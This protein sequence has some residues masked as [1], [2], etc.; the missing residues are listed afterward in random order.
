MEY[1]S[2]RLIVIETV[3]MV[4]W[5]VFVLVVCTNKFSVVGREGQMSQTKINTSTC[6]FLSPTGSRDDR[7]NCGGGGG[8]MGL[9]I[10][11]AHS[12]FLACQCSPLKCE[13]TD[14]V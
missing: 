14:C 1:N 11:F 3:A 5:L 6:F 7:L 10:S 4:V 2:F 12:A 9:L 8:G 13:R